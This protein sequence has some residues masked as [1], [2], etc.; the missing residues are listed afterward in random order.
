MA[1]AILTAAKPFNDIEAEYEVA[2]FLPQ[3]PE[4]VGRANIATPMLSDVDAARARDDQSAGKG[5]QKVSNSRG[6]K[7]TEKARNVSTLTS[8]NQICYTIFS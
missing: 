3:Y 5:T 8:G 7:I 6:Q 1:N 2:P 4:H